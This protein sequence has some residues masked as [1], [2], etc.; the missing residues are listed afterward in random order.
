MLLSVLGVSTIIMLI[1]DIKRRETEIFVW[2][3]MGYRKRDIMYMLVMEHLV[4]VIKA[5]LTAIIVS[6][7]FVFAV[8]YVIQNCL[9]FYRRTIVI[10]W[11]GNTLWMIGAILI[12][13]AV[14]A[15]IVAGY[16]I[17]YGKEAERKYL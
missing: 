14:I 8:N 17:A 3:T 2:K 9:P 6:V 12:V 11:Q 16:G 5:F 1:S 4:L 7:V 10:Q 15:I 13:S